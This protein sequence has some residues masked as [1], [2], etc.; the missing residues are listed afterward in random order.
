MVDNPTIFRPRTPAEKLD[1]A[2]VSKR[3]RDAT[4]EFRIRKILEKHQQDATK[5]HIPFCYRCAKLDAQ[6]RIDKAEKEVA[7]GGIV[8][9]KDLSINPDPYYSMKRFELLDSAEARERTIIGTSSTM[10]VIGTHYNFQCRAR[11]CGISVFVPV[12]EKPSWTEVEADKS[13]K[14]KTADIEP[15]SEFIDELEK[16][17]E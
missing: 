17:E 2:D 12:N 5:A 16:L 1:F 11:G 15:R 10:A 8:D 14:A 13:V 9:N 7:R 3:S 4:P 6:D